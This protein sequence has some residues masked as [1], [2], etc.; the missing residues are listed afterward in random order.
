MGSGGG[1]GSSN[2]GPAGSFGGQGGNPAANGGGDKVAAAEPTGPV[3]LALLNMRKS[4]N[5]KGTG[6]VQSSMF[7]QAE[8]AQALARAQNS[9]KV[10]GINKNLK[11]KLPE[12]GIANV[13]TE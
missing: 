5:W 1:G 11:V 3:P 8:L 7:T 9:G 13:P 10:D 4:K 12:T 2:A 6:R